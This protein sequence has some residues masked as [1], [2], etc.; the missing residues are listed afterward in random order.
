MEVHRG[1][2]ALRNADRSPGSIPCF[3]PPNG[4]ERA[5][6]AA[7]VDR[8]FVTFFTELKSAGVPVTLREYLTLMEAMEK[9]LAGRRVEDFYYLSR[10]SLG[11]GVGH[12]DKFDRVFGHVFKGLDLLSESLTAEIPEEWLK[13]LA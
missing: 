7:I 8:M 2:F 6:F 12:L 3:R 9:D 4:V 11:K 10:A 1:A 5:R 13:K